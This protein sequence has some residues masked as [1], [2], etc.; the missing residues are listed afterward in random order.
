ME[1]EKLEEVVNSFTISKGKKEK[2]SKGA[3]QMAST[4]AN[5]FIS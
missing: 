2:P 4:Q 5:N 3:Q 1:K